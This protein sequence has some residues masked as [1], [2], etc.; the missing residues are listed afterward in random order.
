[1]KG[2]AGA[3][4]GACPGHNRFAC[5][6][7]LAVLGAGAAGVLTGATA[8]QSPAQETAPQPSDA[9]AQG[10]ADA[11]ADPQSPPPDGSPSGIFE[12]VIERARSRAGEPFSPP[13]PAPLPETLRQLG[14]RQYRDIE[15]KP[16]QALWT[17][18]S[19]F[20]VQFHH[21][22][23]L[24]QSP[25][26]IN[27]V[28]D[29]EVRPVEYSPDQ[30]DLGPNGEL[31]ESLSDELGYAGL[32]VHYPINGP[33]ETS[34][35]LSFLGASY[36]RMVGRDQRFGLSA[37]GLAVDTALPSGE[38]FPHFV[39]FWLVRPAPDATTLTFYALLDSESVTGAYRFEFDPNRGGQLAVDSHLFARRDVA[40]LGIA[41]LTSMFMWGE[42]RVRPVDDHRPEVHDSDGL[43]VHTGNDEWI[44]RPLSNPAEA[45]VSS[46]LDRNPQG[47]GLVQRDRDFRS[48]QDPDRRF[49]ERPSFWVT[50]HG[51]WGAGAVQLIEIPSQHESNDNI[52]A[53]WV[54]DKRLAAGE[55]RHIAYT[56]ES[57]WSRRDAQKLATVQRTR[58]GQGVQGEQQEER[59]PQ[60]VR[61]FVVDFTGGPL[62]RMQ[63]RQP[64]RARLSAVHG[65]ARAVSV[66]RL[67][68]ESG[69]RVAFNLAPDGSGRAAD[70]RLSL[71]LH[72]HRLSETWNYVWD[73]KLVR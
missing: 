20:S 18:R 23:F 47:F 31:R 12:R 26:T 65:E 60:G 17:D 2:L 48:Y 52:V 6:L 39:A 73:P 56:L 36:F 43:L 11:A 46:L 64:V 9:Q 72:G 53:F 71:W 61:R 37:R 16:E 59:P 32:R 13:Q 35:V 58:I 67:P 19:R 45:Q 63:N 41:P 66:R 27:E 38:E 68:D 51:D 7:L 50:P 49:G 55:H 54:P 10:G 70:M 3:Q 69:W 25:V 44:W 15:F 4:E 5:V 42:N 14:D 33:D 57:F 24:Y 22:G 30:F 1:M 21:L 28:V 8:S 62:A 40:K 34:A 29:G